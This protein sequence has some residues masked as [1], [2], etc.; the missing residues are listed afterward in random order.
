MRTKTEQKAEEFFSEELESL[1][2]I[3]W[4]YHYFSNKDIKISVLMRK[5]KT[6]YFL[7]AEWEREKI[8]TLQTTIFSVNYRSL[9]F[10]CK[11][12]HNFFA[13]L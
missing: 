4:N 13:S 6:F 8:K 10:R 12:I 11:F 3:N 1:L 7:F 2:L 5:E 9:L